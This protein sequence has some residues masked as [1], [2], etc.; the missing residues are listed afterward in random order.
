M[1]DR[2][3]DP[4]YALGLLTT[5]NLLVVFWWLSRMT[6]SIHPPASLTPA[7]VVLIPVVGLIVWWLRRSG[8]RPRRAYAL[9][10]A[11]FLALSWVP[12]A[13]MMMI[14]AL[15]AEPWP[16]SLRQGPD[17]ASA[18]EAFR[19]AF[20]NE[21]PASVSM[22]YARMEWAGPGE[23]ITSIA[24]SYTDDAVLRGIV[25][26]LALR[27][28]PPEEIAQLGAFPAPSWF[29]SSAM[30]KQLPEAYKQPRTDD[31]QVFVHLWVDR[32]R[33]K[34]YFQDVDVG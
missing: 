29:P 31:P 34:V 11:A 4:R 27:A 32:A 3:R 24:F 7:L 30:L 8:A 13:G 33:R 18:R 28:V 16:L 20:G 10:S 2:W 6:R 26:K 14:H 17:T 21:P 5:L 23:H 1:T 12:M 9:L 19:Q 25:D 15:V 22:L